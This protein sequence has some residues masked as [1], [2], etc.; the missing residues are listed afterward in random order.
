[1]PDESRHNLF[2]FAHKALRFGHCRMLAALG[3]HDFSD[4]AGSGEL[5]GTLTQLIALGR[6]HLESRK[7]LLHPALEARRRGAADGLEQDH[8]CHVAALA[9]LES[10]IRA[11]NVATQQRRNI[12]GRTLYRCYALFAAADMGRMDT[13]ETALLSTLHHTFTDG[14]LRQLESRLL[15]FLPGEDLGT[16]LQLMIP[17]LNAPER[18]FFL[19]Q[20]EGALAPESY[21]AMLE[22][23]VHPLLVTMDSAA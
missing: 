21:S 11:V 16:C 10:L 23:I 15:G 9:E 2:Y 12:A 4:D 5:L 8:A 22:E 13:E 6:A 1:M 19:G 3:M 18:Q 20:L 14:E 7:A 17:A